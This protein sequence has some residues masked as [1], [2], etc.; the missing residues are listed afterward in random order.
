MSSSSSS[1]GIGVAGLLFVALVVLK[2]LGL[3]ELGWFWVLS[4]IVWIPLSII[5]IW[6]G[7][8]GIV[9]LFTLLGVFLAELLSK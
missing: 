4:S 1:S 9:T 2:V 6:L 7:F 8:I 3:I 5:A